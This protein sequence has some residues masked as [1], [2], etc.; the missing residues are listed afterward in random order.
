MTSAVVVQVTL[1][2]GLYMHPPWNWG[3]RT[4]KG[5][6]AA[7]PRALDKTAS[8]LQVEPATAVE[9]DITAVAEPMMLDPMVLDDW[10]PPPM[11]RGPSKKGPRKAVRVKSTK[12]GKKAAPQTI[13]RDCGQV[14]LLLHT[15]MLHVKVHDLPGND[16]A[17]V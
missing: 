2:N 1:L 11:R 16:T 13:C 3:S 4:I 17:V 6:T 5:R 9:A 15:Y 10:E 7:K 12:G 14:P 8:Q